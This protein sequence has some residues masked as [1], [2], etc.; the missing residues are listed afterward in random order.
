M[1][2]I[3]M[4]TH[5]SGR[6]FQPYGYS[7]PTPNI[8]RMASQGLLFRNA[9]CCAPTFVFVNPK[10]QFKCTKKSSSGQRVNMG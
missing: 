10:I 9:Y 3:Y 6:Y 8:M 2:I 1:N 7:I 4:H 5:D